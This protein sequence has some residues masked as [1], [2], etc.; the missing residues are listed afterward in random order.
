MS[1]VHAGFD[2]LNGKK[3]QIDCDGEIELDEPTLE[4]VRIVIGWSLGPFVLLQLF[5]QIK[6]E[7]HIS[8]AGLTP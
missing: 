7:T 6:K 8:Q 1:K 3:I 2:N 5:F 4:A